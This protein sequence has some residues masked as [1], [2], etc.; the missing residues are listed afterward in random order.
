M[1]D[2][3]T[4]KMAPA[5]S[6]AELMKQFQTGAAPTPDQ[7]NQ[8]SKLKAKVEIVADYADVEKVR[9]LRTSSPT[10][11]ASSPS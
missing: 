4:I 1:I 3:Y 2:R 9:D 7:V 11:K 6:H 5:I 10:R 8:L